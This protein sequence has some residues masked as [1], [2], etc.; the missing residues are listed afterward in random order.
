MNLAQLRT[1]LRSAVGSPTVNDVT[2]DMLTSLINK[3][4]R[5]IATVYPNLSSRVVVTTQTVIGTQDYAVPADCFAVREVWD[6][7]NNV[8]LTKRGERWAAEHKWLTP[9]NARPHSYVRFVNVLQ[10]WPPPDGIYNIDMY[11]QQTIQDMAADSDVPVIPIPWHDGLVLKARWYYYDQLRSDI[12]K[13]SASDVSWR[14]WLAEMPT[15]LDQE[16]VD[17]DSGVELPTLRRGRHYRRDFDHS[18]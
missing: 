10:L 6:S 1:D 16:T 13:A 4:H 17:I 12:P 7:T 8:K 14:M 11:Y 15:S 2:D 5:Y 9:T 3:A 18:D